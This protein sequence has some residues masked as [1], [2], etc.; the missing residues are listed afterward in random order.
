MSLHY[1]DAPN[2]RY[3]ITYL[4]RASY[5]HQVASRHDER[6]D[7]TAH[8]EQDA[9]RGDRRDGPERRCKDS[10]G[11]RSEWTLEGVLRED[12][13]RSQSL[14][15]TRRRHRT[16]TCVGVRRLDPQ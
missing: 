3:L 5:M 4:T 9:R 11:R 16:D 8:Q 10:G 6:R 12:S 2:A 14:G 15:R 13:E 7:V 1:H